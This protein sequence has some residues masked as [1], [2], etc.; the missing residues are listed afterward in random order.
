MT[1]NDCLWRR[2]SISLLIRAVLMICC[3][4][5]R[6]SFKGTTRHTSLWCVC[7]Y[8]STTAH[9]GG[10]LGHSFD[11]T[12]FCALRHYC[13]RWQIKSSNFTLTYFCWVSYWWGVIQ[14]VLDQRKRKLVNSSF[15][16]KPFKNNI[17]V[18]ILD[19]LLN[20]AL[21]AHTFPLTVINP[22]WQ[23]NYGLYISLRTNTFH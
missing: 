1:N 3:P 7:L 18:I 4:T 9:C 2:S 10:R 13:W 15:Y 17:T 6:F 8:C 16:L 5:F 21:L 20:F 22:D 12:V 14:H 23:S 11:Y 19:V